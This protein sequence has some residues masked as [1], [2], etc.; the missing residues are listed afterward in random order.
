MR[1]G[2]DG[3]QGAVAILRT[4]NNKGTMALVMKNASHGLS[5]GHFDKL[6][7]SLYED[8][9]EVIQDYGLARYVNVEQKNGGGYLK[10]NTT[11]AKQT[12]AHNTI[13]Q[14]QTSHFKG[15]F[16]ESSKHHP[17][18]TIFNIDDT[19]LQV[20]GAR[21]ENAYPGTVITRTMMMVQLGDNEKPLII[22]INQ[23]ESDRKHQYDLPTYY[24][25]QL[26][27]TGFTI[28]PEESLNPLG[29]SD[30]YQHIWKEATGIPQG[31]SNTFTWLSNKKF[32]SMTSLS[33]K[34]DMFI[35]GRIGANDPEYNLRS[36]PMLIHRKEGQKNALF[37]QVIES[38][39]NYNPVT[40]K[41]LNAYSRVRSLQSI[42]V[43]DGY[44]AI[45]MTMRSGKKHM[46]VLV[47]NAFAKAE[48]TLSILGEKYTWKGIY[49]I[50]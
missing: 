16:K 40:E 34:E 10:E 36:E 46:I 44:T 21:E 8:G 9:E 5:H 28:K 32:Y 27:S 38:H 49:T 4:N 19:K 22:D 39:G 3:K 35:M 17:E 25:G 6:S 14:D 7:Y 30:G 23:L 1:D 48:H 13:I 31:S 20:V 18:A 45:E 11:W 37:V 12:I 15:V 41:A 26:I 24:K 2:P 50:Q 33:N 43:D 29:D 47:D 42:P